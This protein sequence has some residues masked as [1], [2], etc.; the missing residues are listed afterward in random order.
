MIQ[1]VLEYKKT[2]SKQYFSNV[3]LEDE[4]FKIYKISK[5]QFPATIHKVSW[6]QFTKMSKIGLFWKVQ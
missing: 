1:L 6:D 2:V 5:I 3:I 4:N